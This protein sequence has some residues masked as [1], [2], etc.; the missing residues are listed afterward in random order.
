MSSHAIEFNPVHQ[1]SWKSYLIQ[2]NPINLIHRWIQSMSNCGLAGWKTARNLIR[3]IS[4]KLLKML[5]PDVIF[6]GKNAP[7]S[8]S[9]GAPSQNPLG[10]AYSAPPDPLAGIQEAHFWGKGRRQENR[11][12]N[13]GNGRGKGEDRRGEREGAPPPPEK[14]SCLR[15]WR[16]SVLYISYTS[17]IP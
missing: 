17:N 16:A 11:G 10:G 4:G 13:G 12:G 15:H 6:W 8:I 1:V 2:P 14:K 5:P 9:A 7:N 3:K